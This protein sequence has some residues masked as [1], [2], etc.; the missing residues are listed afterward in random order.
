MRKT[1]QNMTR[2]PGKKHCSFRSGLSL[3]LVFCLFLIFI[4]YTPVAGE[5]EQVVSTVSG[6]TMRDVMAGIASVEDVY[7]RLDSTSVPEA[8]GYDY[9]VSKT[10]VQR[11]YEEEGDDLNRVVFLNA[12]GTQTAYLFD[13]PVKYR[14]DIGEI[15]DISLDIADSGVSGRFET[16]GNALTTTF[17]KHITEGI[18]LTGQQISLSLRPHLPIMEAENLTAG[19]KATSE[20]VAERV[21]SKK[22]SYYYD[23][24]T[25]LEYSLTYTGF[26]EDIVVR[27]Y[28][29][30]TSYDFTLYTNGLHLTEIDGSFFLTDEEQT[31]RATLGDIVIFTADERNNTMGE[32]HAQTV[33]EN[34]EYLL[35]IEVSPEFLASEDTVYP[36][37]IDPTIEICYDNNGAAAISDVTINSATDS[38]AT[39]TAIFVGVRRDYG[40]ARILM[41]FPGLD[42]DSLGNNIQ[43]VS[44][45]VELRDLMC[46]AEEIDVSCYVFTGNVW[47]ESTVE[48]ANVNPNSYSTFLSSHTISYA[49]GLEQTYY[50]RYP[51]DITTAVRGWKA[52]N[53]NPDK[54]IIFKSSN[55]FE[56][57]STYDYKTIASYNRASYKPSL[58]VT[59]YTTQRLVSDDTYYLNNTFCGDY[60]R[61]TS[62]G[63]SA[64]SGLIDSLGNSI[65][66]EIRS[67]DGRYAIRSKADPTCYLGVAVATDSS[68]LVM[69]TVRDSAIP[70]RCLWEI[71]GAKN[72]GCLIRSVAT[73][74]YLYSF[75]TRVYVSP[76]TGA[77]GTSTYN[78]RVWRIVS[79]SYYGNGSSYNAREATS[80]THVKYTLLSVGKKT[81]PSVYKAYP[82]ESWCSASDFTYSNYSTSLINI[83]SL[84]GEITA[85]SVGKAT[86][87]AVHK[88]TGRTSTFTVDVS[89]LLI[90]QTPA[91]YYYDED[92]NYGEDMMC[93]DKT[94]ED[95]CEW[96]QVTERDC[97][98]TTAAEHRENWENMCT[99]NF[100]TGEMENVILDMISHFMSGS[101]TSYSNDVLTQRIVEHDSTQKY[102]STVKS[103]FSTLLNTYAGNIG[104]L[105]YSASERGHHPF[106]EILQGTYQPE[107]NTVADKINGLSICV[108]GLWGNKIELY[109]FNTS[110]NTYTYT[111]HFTLYDHFGLDAEDVEKN[112]IFSGFKS[113][114]VLQHYDGYNKSYRPFL[115]LMEF[116]VT[117]SG[118]YS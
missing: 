30:Q 104:A 101:G 112:S 43:I 20:S 100:A 99:R 2:K 114:Y 38:S 32:L 85:K 51:F 33:V 102:V 11:L 81:I 46:E 72:G 22:I 107:Y 42:L 95:L 28:T 23:S 77:D 62:S 70:V 57:G 116:D 94:K 60:L 117:V 13:Y 45:A 7:G 39:S 64:E 93:G 79:T 65:Q 4:P 96:G 31:V 59:Y 87:T 115:T 55:S 18:C 48:W 91:T 105:E 88:V 83:N 92:G 63:T 111:L 109:S 36:I 10:H 3:L 37:R 54:G 41:K 19:E 9:A 67:V 76:D 53:L 118:T 113:W 58:S 35:T 71:V 6:P 49:K 8:V 47:D 44:A 106:V 74:K 56:T 103:K 97:L 80:G 16:A 29:G 17:S 50:H 24:K 34:Q 26:K 1:R 86:V 12:D 66:W 68:S 61:H 89:G 108:N 78:S 73:S 25:S 21:N 84:T 40:I 15:Q 75:G 27:E 98:E 69:A 14:N 82:N 52:G 110:G 90:Y 5:S